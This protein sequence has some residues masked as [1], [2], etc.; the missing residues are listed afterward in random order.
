MSEHEDGREPDDLPDTDD[1]PGGD[2]LPEMDSDGGEDTDGI[3]E[4]ENPRCGF[5]ALVGAPNAGKSTLLNTRSRVLGITTV[6][7]AELLFVDLPGIFAPKKRLER[8][9]VAAAWQG[10]TDADLIMVLYDAVRSRIDDDTKGI[11]DRLKEQGRSAILVLNKIDLIHPERLLGLAQTFQ[12]EGIF[13]DIFMISAATGD[14]IDRLKSHLAAAVPEGP[15]LY[16]PDQLSDM[17]SRLMA[18]EITR[19]KLFLQLH[20]EL[21]YA[22][23]VE[24]E[25]WEEFDDGSVK[26]SQVVYVQRDS[27]KAIV[28]GKGGSKVKQ[29]GAAS[30]RELEELLDRRVHLFLFVKVRENWTDDP[31]RYEAWGLDFNA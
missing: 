21:P 27:Q 13:T 8:A 19:E 11:I 15:W 17:P 20:Q 18:A 24:T 25:S 29:I 5:V 22:T 12:A 4:P 10:A 28:L 14:G 31:E 23:T 30:R 1:L 16:P 7:D 2:D 3:T 9:M 6:G 26:I